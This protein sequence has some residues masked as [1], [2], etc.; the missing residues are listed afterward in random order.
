M[1]DLGAAADA[2]ID[3]QRMSPSL[4]GLVDALK[5][6][7]DSLQ[8]IVG[9]DIVVC[10]GDPGSGKSTLLTSLAASPSSLKPCLIVRDNTK[11]RAIALKSTS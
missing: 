10:M 3:P 6:V 11:K 8:P 9:K 7:L 1:L 2:W 4:A 5:Q